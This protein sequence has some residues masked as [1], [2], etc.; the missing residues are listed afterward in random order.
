MIIPYIIAKIII[1]IWLRFLSLSNQM[2]T[3]KVRARESWTE[4]KGQGGPGVGG[5]GVEG[6]KRG[7]VL[8]AGLAGMQEEPVS[9]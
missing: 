1:Y 7:S 2:E 6:K 3:L 5:G 8:G 4:Q 9:C